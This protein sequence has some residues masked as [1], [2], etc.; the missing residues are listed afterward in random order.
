[1]IIRRRSAALGSSVAITAIHAR[2]DTAVLAIDAAYEEIERLESV[3]SIYRPGSELSRLN[4]TALL[5][6]PDS[7][8]VEVLHYAEKAWQFSAGAFDATVQPLWELYAAAKRRGELPSDDE[9]AAARNKVDWRRVQISPERVRLVGSGTAVTLNGIAQGYVADQAMKALLEHGVEHA[10]VD[11]GEMK[12]NGR[13]RN[14]EP[15]SV[16]IQHPRDPASLVAVA[17]LDGRCLATSGD[18]ATTFSADRRFNHLF[19]PATG[20]SPLGL[21]SVSIVA[22]TAIEA[23]ALST[24]CFVLGLTR[25]MDLI[26]TRPGVDAYFIPTEGEPISTPGFPFAGGG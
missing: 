4:R 6:R 1:M 9:I 24:A 13:N 5:E 10:L 19:D 11:A 17:E 26:A 12:P 22:P 16:G 20:R 18:Y 21:G 23:D 3:L 8:L 15:W 14:Q 7:S 2:V 25:A